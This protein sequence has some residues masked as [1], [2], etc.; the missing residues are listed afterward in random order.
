[1]KST[2][3]RKGNI[4]YNSDLDIF[5]KGYVVMEA[6][7]IYE[8]A[9]FES[10]QTCEKYATRFTPI[11]ISEEWLVKLGFTKENEGEYFIDAWSKGHPSARFEIEYRNGGIL[12]KSRY[13]ESNDDL[14]MNHVEFIHQ[15]QNLYHSLTGEE[16]IIKE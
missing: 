14:R 5:K 3:L 1:M 8:L 11:K 2:D 7:W 13:Q 15:L 4:T 6:R 9:V 12:L 16:L 10:A